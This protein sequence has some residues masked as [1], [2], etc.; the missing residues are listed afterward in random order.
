MNIS[1]QQLEAAAHGTP[2]EIVEDNQ[3][4][5]LISQETYEKL[6]ATFAD[7]DPEIVYPAVLEAWDSM[8]SPDD[9]TDYL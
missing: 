5:V 1:K 2:V 9:A 3:T 4:F 8:G 6:A 7:D